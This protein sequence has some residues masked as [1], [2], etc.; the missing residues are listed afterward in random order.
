MLY[1]PCVPGPRPKAPM[2]STRVARETRD[3]GKQSSTCRATLFVADDERSLRRQVARAS[4]ARLADGLPE[5]TLLGIPF[6]EMDSI[7]DVVRA[8]ADKRG[9]EV[10]MEDRIGDGGLVH[11]DIWLAGAERSGIV[12]DAAPPGP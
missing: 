1:W 11:L 10:E 7:R 3:L 5:T 2:T 9:V 4:V 6:E 12:A 8:A